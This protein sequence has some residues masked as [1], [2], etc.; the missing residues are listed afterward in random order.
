[1]IKAASYHVPGSYVK[2]QMYTH[3]R[4]RQGVDSHSLLNFIFQVSVN[5][6]EVLTTLL[7]WVSEVH[8]RHTVT[9][10]PTKPLE[11]FNNPEFMQVKCL[12]V[13]TT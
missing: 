2:I 7:E 3:T 8:L 4:T 6:Y 1:M 13:R 5:T 12:K 9:E 10:Q 11:I